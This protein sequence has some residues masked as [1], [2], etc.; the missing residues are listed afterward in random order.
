MT[1]ISRPKPTFALPLRH[2]PRDI[3]MGQALVVVTI[4]FAVDQSLLA[5]IGI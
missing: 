4:N 3:R 2:R 5:N 1:G